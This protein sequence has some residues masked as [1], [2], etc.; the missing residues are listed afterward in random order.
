MKTVVL[1]IGLA[2]MLAAVPAA[3]SMTVG[4]DFG[5]VIQLPDNWT[6]V[7]KTEVRSKPEVVKGTFEAASKDKS[8]GDMPEDLYS[9]VKEKLLG[10]EVEYYYKN[11]SPSFNISVY[12]DTGTLD[13][14]DPGMK[15]TCGLLPQE[16]S[17]LTQKPVTVHEC[18]SRQ[19]GNAHALYMVVDGL[20]QGEKYI[21]Y[22]IQKSPNRLLMLTATSSKEQ[23]FEAMRSE[24]DQITKSFKL[25]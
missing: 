23:D 9:K 16:L 18:G 20:R 10:G 17:K 12:E 22:L 21:Q 8:L 13:Q 15:K 24:F 6:A 5:F 19:I 1:L 14:S 11:T 25:L 3:L 7:S 2:A 4:S